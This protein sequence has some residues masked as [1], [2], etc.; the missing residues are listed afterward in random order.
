MNTVFIKVPY[1]G[2]TRSGLVNS[3]TLYSD[4]WDDFGYKTTFTLRLFDKSG[5][6]LEVGN[7]RIGFIGQQSG[8]TAEKMPDS[9]HELDPMFYSLGQDIEYYRNLVDNLDPEE[10]KS[11]LLALGDVVVSDERLSI[12][13]QETAFHTSLM[14]TINKTTIDHQ[15]KRII[16]GEAPLTPYDFTFFKPATDRSAELSLSFS[17]KPNSKPSSNIHI[18]IGRNGVGKTTILNNMVQALVV[19]E[20]QILNSGHFLSKDRWG[21]SKNYR[22]EFAGVVSVSFSAFDAFEPPPDQDDPENGMRYRYVGLKTNLQNSDGDIRPLKG[23]LEL[24]NELAESLSVCLA[25]QAKKI[26]WVSAIKK[27]ESD[28]NFEEMNLLHVIERFDQDLSEE[29]TEFKKYSA[30]FFRLMSSGHTVVLLTIT[31]LIE[32]V[33]EKTLVLIDEPESHLH[34]P[35]LSAFTRALSDLLTN[36]N[37]VAII[38]THSPVVLQEVPKSC[39]SIVDRLRLT[40]TVAPPDAETFGENVGTLTRHVFGLQ[41]TSSGFH[42]LLNV[43]VSKGR[44]YEEIIQEYSDQIGYEGKAILRSL[45]LARDNGSGN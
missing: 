40:A 26:R 10:W 4:N 29:K 21:V 7:V 24:C 32:T 27:L 14:R 34:P 33:D 5:S 17:V 44:S 19:K 39:V 16:N 2:A 18:L 25:L 37:A 12:A 36:R 41:V 22:K 28:H 1:R 38:A 45:T 30:G 31:Q 15:F 3:A 9:F 43:E 20:N 23:K 13:E 35:L 8:W 42:E 11:I 6:E